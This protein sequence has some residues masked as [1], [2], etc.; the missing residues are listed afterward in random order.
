MAVTE[1]PGDFNYLWDD[2]GEI[3]EDY[4]FDDF[5][6]PYDMR[7]STMPA[8][9]QTP[10]PWYRASAAMLAMGAIGVAVV[11]I[12]VSAV[13]LVSRES[14]GA[15]KVAPATTVPSSSAPRTIESSVIATAPPSPPPQGPS[16]VTAS[17]PVAAAPHPQPQAPT[18]PPEI[19]VTR[20]PVTRTQISVRP[21]PRPPEGRQ[22]YPHY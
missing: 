13:L 12:L 17:A 14:R 2:L 9:D 8:R 21:Q 18:K 4:G 7:S 5:D 20:T 10:V 15:P 16:E 11:A 22:N 6:N 1:P 19:G 3:D